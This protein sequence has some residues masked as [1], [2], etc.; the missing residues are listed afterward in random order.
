L[1]LAVVVLAVQATAHQWLKQATLGL[2]LEII[3]KILPP[4]QH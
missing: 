3:M 2:L 4:Q 1:P